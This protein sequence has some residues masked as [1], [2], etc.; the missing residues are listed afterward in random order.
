MSNKPAVIQNFPRVSCLQFDGSDTLSETSLTEKKLVRPAVIEIDGDARVVPGGGVA[1]S[2][3]AEGGGGTIQA[4]ASTRVR[5]LEGS[6]A[7]P[8]AQHSP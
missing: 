6:R 4:G 1:R 7:R 5:G 3:G 2:S 8:M